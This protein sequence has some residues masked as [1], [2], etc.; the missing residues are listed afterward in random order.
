MPMTQHRLGVAPARAQAAAQQPEAVG[1]I[2]RD[3]RRGPVPGGSGFIAASVALALVAAAVAAS[4]VW[5]WQLERVGGDLHLSGGAPLKG[6]IDWRV[7]PA[8]VA[9]LLVAGAA[10]GLMPLAARRLHWAALVALSGLAATVWAVALAAT[11]DLPAL[12]APLERRFDYLHDV[13]RVDDVGGVLRSFTAHVRDGSPGFQ[14]T[15]HVGGHPPGALLTFVGLARLGLGGAGWAA[16]FC[17]AVG[18]SAV[19]AVLITVRELAGERVARRVA[20]FVALSP[21]A[22][23]VATSA[24]AFFCAVAAWGVCCLAM[25][26][27]RTGLRGDTLALAGGVV[28]GASLFLSYGLILMAP[29]AVA[30]VAIRRRVRPLLVGA[31]GVGVVVAAFAA[32][33]FWWL[34]G[35]SAAAERVR[36]GAAWQDRP[37]SYFLV[38][39]VAALAVA[40]GP[41]TVAGLATLWRRRSSTGGAVSWTAGP[42]RAAVVLP[43]AA[44]SAVAVGFASNL[45]KGEVERIYLPFS[46]WLLVA[47]GALLGSGRRW[48]LA[49]QV[50]L[51]VV[52]QLG[53]RLRW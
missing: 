32:L 53:W 13:P 16:A 9:P 15:T 24:D 37:T 14:W 19:P 12:A 38:A 2:G 52:V 47:A 3:R 45:S 36:D 8:V 39:N 49:A 27:G 33:G 22:L 31:V 7:S 4:A 21:L 28:L 18:A 30:V 46:V 42:L 5:G 35:L 17:I 41:A 48:W 50:V 1:A 44:L 23:W 26:A 43:V 11:D 34:E 25:A 10:I 6:P 40:T 29:V 51:A 20:P